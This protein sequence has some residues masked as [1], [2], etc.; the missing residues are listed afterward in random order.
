MET[1]SMFD[2]TTAR[3]INYGPNGELTTTVFQDR[4]EKNIWYLVPVPRLRIQNGQPAFSLTR[5][6]SNGGGLAGMCTFETELYAPEEAKQAAQA[7]IPGIGG[8]GQFTWVSG[9][10]FFTYEFADN[11]PR[12]LVQSPSLFGSNVAAFQVELTNEAELNA[13]VTGF[14][15]PGEVSPFRVKYE[16][17]VLTQLL[18]A[19]ATVT[20][21][22]SAAIEYQRK[23][24]TRTDTWGNR[25]TVLTEVRQVL[26]QSGA[27]DVKVTPG[28]GAT[29]EVVQLVRD[30]AWSTL[31]TQVANTV[32]SA[33]ALAVGNENPVTATSDFSA[34]YSEDAI[35][36]WSTPVS[37][38]LPRFSEDTWKLLYHQVDNRQLVVTFQLG[39]QTQAEDGTPLFEDVV[40]AVRY[41]TLS[42]DQTFTLLPGSDQSARTFTA[43]G[44]G[45]FDPT[46]QYRFTVNFPG[47][48]PPYNSD[49]I[50]STATQVDLRP[51]LFGIRN[52]RFV[53]A[54]VPFGKG[55]VK[56][57]FVDFFD[58]PPPGQPSKLQTKEMTANGPEAAV[59]FTSTYHVPITE[60]YDY[61][62]RYLFENGTLVTVQ[63]QQQF[64]TNNADLVQVLSPAPNVANLVLRALVTKDGGGFVN[65]DANAAYADGQG[66]TDGRRLSYDWS[67]W[68]PGEK[69]GLYSSDT[70]TFDARPNPQTAF[71]TLNGQVIYGDGDIVPLSSFNLAYTKKPL[72][73]KDTEELYSVEILPDQVD[74]SMVT[75]V[76]VNVFQ[77]VDDQGSVVSAPVQVVMAAPALGRRPEPVLALQELAAGR[78]T[79]LVPYTVLAPEQQATALPLFYTLRRPRT[80]PFLV[81]Y[82]NATY[83]MADGTHRSI[84]DTEVTGKLQIHLPQLPPDTPPAIAGAMLEALPALPADTLP[85]V[86]Q[87]FAVALGSR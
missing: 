83:V 35:V 53:G 56:S 2:I 75:A 85:G 68:A 16:M 81:F 31:E 79:A 43:P 14:T 69:P 76:T 63:P 3:Q 27:G 49:W 73:F 11:K 34:T 12:S 72:I 20:Y 80:D 86:V 30:W 4:T 13:F 64:G 66:Q 9:N 25:K 55:G 28:A 26:Q 19:A 29:D 52:V 41:P 60:T 17:G 57:V 50:T 40:I 84:G 22:A 47:G 38:F 10:A 15:T 51:N 21:R 6:V 45:S 1:P 32:E 59:T 7:Q 8:W 67:G 36:E 18:G 24:E 48:V 42:G 58:N 44:G 5:Y 33:R 46:Y 37:R 87:R 78:T 70:W 54:N 82:F 23:Y 77:V 74:W 71:F 39:G 65:I 62:L 61:R